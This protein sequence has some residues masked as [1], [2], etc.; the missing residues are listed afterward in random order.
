MNVRA[1]AQSQTLTTRLKALLREGVKLLGIALAC[2]VVFTI[3]FLISMKTGITV[4]KRWF[5][6]VGW[7][8]LLVWAVCRPYKGQLTQARFWIAFLPLLLL[9][10]AAFTVVL[11][12]YPN[13]GM[14]WFMPFVLVEAPCMAMALEA[15]VHKR[16]H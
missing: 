9:H 4:P 12:R 13:W 5:G 11:E 2:L 1:P 8:G 16:S 7:T 6:L 14:N 10:L 15:V 3:V